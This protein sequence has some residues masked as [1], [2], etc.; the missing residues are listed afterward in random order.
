M[1]NRRVILLDIEQKLRRDFSDL[2]ISYPVNVPKNVTKLG[3]IFNYHNNFSESN[4]DNVVMFVALHDPEGFRGH[5]MN[6]GGKG[7]VSLELW[8]TPNNSSE[9]AIPGEIIPGEWTVKI[10]IRALSIETSYELHVY[11]ETADETPEPINIDYPDAH[12]VKSEPGW[13]KGELHA[14]STESDGRYEVEDVIDAAKKYGLDFFALTDHTTCSQWYKLAKLQNPSTALIRSM[15]ITS[16]LGHANLHGIKN[17]INVYIDEPGWSANQAAEE[18]HKQG[19]LFCVNHAFSGHL[20]WRDFD[21]DWGLVDMEEIYH[22]LEGANNSY[23]LSLWDQ[24]LNQGFRIVGVAGIDS[25]N[26]YEGI[27]EL[28]QLVTCVY[29]DELSEK[30]IIEGLRRGQVYIS[31]GPDFRFNAKTGNIEAAMWES[32]PQDGPITLEIDVKW[33]KPLNLFIIKNGLILDVLKTSSTDDDWQ[34]ITFIDPEPGLKNQTYYRV[35]LHDDVLNLPYR[36]IIWRDFSTMRVLS[37]PIW[38]GRKK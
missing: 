10:D 29:A 28:G 11:I 32:L 30:G 22:N 21:L 1:K 15:E 16:H 23:Q 4:S 9:G 27:H 14:H 20:S 5:R 2:Y 13:Y 33:N 37:N 12:I 35:E 38:V 25:H 34:K 36:G 6:P 8:T 7:D 18:V 17:W 3:L 26:P 24:H 31:R 19:G